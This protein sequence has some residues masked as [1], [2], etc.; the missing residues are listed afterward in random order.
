MFGSL[1]PLELGIIA[2]IVILLFGAGKISG[3][4]KD[5]GS[6]IKEFRK[7]VKDEDDPSKQQQAQ[8]KVEPPQQVAPPQQQYTAP[9]PAQQQ[10]PSQQPNDPQKNIF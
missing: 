2:L 4:G 1:G 10:P 8:A 5:L 3:L 9:P 6:S 7:A